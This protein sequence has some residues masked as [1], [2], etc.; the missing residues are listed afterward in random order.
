MYY[1][2]Y[3]Y[4]YN[5]NNHNIDTININR[6]FIL[7]LLSDATQGG[8]TQVV[9]MVV[10]VVVAV[11]VARAESRLGTRKIP[12]GVGVSATLSLATGE[13]NCCRPPV[14]PPTRLPAHP[15]V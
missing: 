11:A 6:V 3:Y 9:V 14:Y 12:E 2:Y 8:E 1:N 7:E 10:V 15:Y 5:Y 4:Y 13:D